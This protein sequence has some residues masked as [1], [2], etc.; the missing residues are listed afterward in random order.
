[1]LTPHTPLVVAP[2]SS[3]PA[4]TPVSAIFQ[5]STRFAPAKEL[6]SSPNAKFFSLGGADSP[7]AGEL[8]ATG[9]AL[10]G[11]AAPVPDA[12]PGDVALT[13]IS[14]GIPLTMTHVVRNTCSIEA[15]ANAD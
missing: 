2:G 5:S 15:P 10:L 13:I 11:D 7:A 9:K 8:L 1:M 14:E 6:S 3:L 4:D 12:Q